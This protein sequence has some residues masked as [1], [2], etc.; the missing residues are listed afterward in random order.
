M[1][2]VDVDHAKRVLEALVDLDPGEIVCSPAARTF[3]YA[4]VD[5]AKAVLEHREEL[6]S[7]LRKF[8]QSFSVDLEKCHDHILILAKAYAPRMLQ[9]GLEVPL[10]D[11]I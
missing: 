9:A 3:I 10:P 2:I 6:I 4:L 11:P 7:C 5:G 8:G 1:D